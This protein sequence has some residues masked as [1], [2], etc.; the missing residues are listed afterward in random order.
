MLNPERKRIAVIG[1]GV[2]GMSAAWLLNRRHDVTVFEKESRIGGHCNTIDLTIGEGMHRQTRPVDTGFI[3][4]NELNY[5]N[6]VRL[7]AHLGVATHASDMSFSVS[8]DRGRLEY[9]GGEWQGLLAQPRNLLRPGY[10]RM[11]QDCLR[12][13]REAPR[14]LAHSAVVNRKDLPANLFKT[15]K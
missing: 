7:L 14:L 15:D 1:S 6:L 10:W 12:F 4:Y 11:L 5:P 3:V 2:A 9:A 8:L 13:F